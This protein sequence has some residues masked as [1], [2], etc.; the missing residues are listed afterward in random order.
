MFSKSIK[1]VFPRDDSLIPLGDEVLQSFQYLTGNKLYLGRKGQAG[2]RTFEAAEQRYF[3]PGDQGWAWDGNFFDYELDGDE[4]LYIANGWIEGSYANKQANRMYIRHADLFYLAHEGGAESFKDNS[5]AVA[6]VDVDRDGDLDLVVTNLRG[7]PRLLK[8]TQ[9]SK[10]HW[11]GVRLRQPGMN[12]R[13]LG[14]RVVLTSSAG[15]QVRLV[16][17]GRGYLSQDDPDRVV[18]GLGT[19]TR[20]RVKIFWPDGTSSDHDVEAGKVLDIKKP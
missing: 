12:T 15:A 17:G 14:A 18:F 7:A 13:A 19:Q 11:A 4:D 10:N 3:E 16:T 20:A 1:I 8:N 6:S 9:A 5:R 2:E